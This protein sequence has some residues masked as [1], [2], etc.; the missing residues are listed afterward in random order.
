MRSP[1]TVNPARP[2]VLR[3]L[4]YLII[5][6]LVISCGEKKERAEQKEEVP[7]FSADTA[8]A[9]VQKQVAFGP[10]IPNSVAHR[11]AGDFIIAT[12]NRYGARTTVQE[13]TALTFDG[14]TLNLR[15]I[16]ASY[17]PKKQKRVL[18]SAHW[19]TRPFAD[20]DP[21][22]ASASFDGANDGASGVAVLLEIA[23]HLGAGMG[24]EVGV[25]LIFFDGEDW[26]EREGEA[27]RAPLPAGWTSWWC[28]GSQYWSKNKHKRGY[29]AQ[30]G[31]L[32]DMVGA[33]DA[34]FFQEG[35]SVTYAPGVVK[36][37]WNTAARMG[38]SSVFIAQRQEAIT[39]DH[40]F[41][42]ETANIPTID[43]THFEPGLGYFGK[44]HHTRQDNLAGISWETLEI[45]GRVVLQ[46]VYDEE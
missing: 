21:E 1:K 26:G 5:G 2:F 27:M 39:D 11:A 19:D 34:H 14:H 6:T 45:V 4:R 37:V 29:Q 8:Y 3:S 38:F 42:N 35:A 9:F 24:P 32:L 13:F 28:L 41:I 18:L 33:R 40:I 23:R 22:N 30:Y 43:I 15:N 25:D 44:T 36:K 31:I 16:I 10:R 46:V 17:Q 7:A 20:K 12:L